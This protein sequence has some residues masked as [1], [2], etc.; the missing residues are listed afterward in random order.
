MP[1]FEIIII[2]KKHEEANH[3]LFNTSISSLFFSVFYQARR[4]KENHKAQS[5]GDKVQPALDLSLLS[6]GLFY[7]P[8]GHGPP[9][10]AMVLLA[11]SRG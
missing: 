11:A 4:N 6:Q 8:E 3:G 10:R 1:Y 2:Q 9:Q 7:L 5:M